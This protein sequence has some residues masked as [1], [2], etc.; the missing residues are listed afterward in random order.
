M[1]RY[2]FK[3]TKLDCQHEMEL[4]MKLSDFTDTVPCGRCGNISKIS[5]KPTNF[6]LKGSGWASDG[7]VTKGS[8]KD[9]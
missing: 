7:Y 8:L 3:C 9:E 2:A 5:Y 6:I 1:P 4:D